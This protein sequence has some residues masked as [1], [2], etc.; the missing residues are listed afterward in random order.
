MRALIDPETHR[1]LEKYSSVVRFCDMVR[2]KY[3]ESTGYQLED[4]QGRPINVNAVRAELYEDKGNGKVGRQ[5]CAA[6]AGNREEALKQ[7]LIKAR[8]A[9]RPATTADELAAQLEEANNRNAQL[10]RELLATRNGESGSRRSNVSNGRTPVNEDEP[11]PSELSD[12]S[13]NSAQDEG[14]GTQPLELIDPT[15]M[16]P[17]R[18]RGRP[19]KIRPEAPPQDQTATEP[20]A[21]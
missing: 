5:W 16:P 18:G 17:K 4:R 21:S 14:D 2:A 7:V 9:T 10:E 20:Q 3:D 19:K 11:A 1:Q 6:E 13:P 8:T 12:A 15:A